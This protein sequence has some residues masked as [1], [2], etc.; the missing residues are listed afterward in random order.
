MRRS[1]VSRARAS[2][3]FC[4]YHGISNNLQ[5]SLKK[6]KDQRIPRG[7]LCEPARR[8]NILENVGRVYRR[9]RVIKSI[10]VNEITSWSF[11]WESP[12][13]AHA[14]RTCIHCRYCAST[15]ES[16]RARNASSRPRNSARHCNQTY[17]YKPT[18]RVFKVNAECRNRDSRRSSF[19]ARAFSII[20]S[21][22][23]RLFTVTIDWISK[24][25][26]SMNSRK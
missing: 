26:E 6:I 11:N 16:K 14:V 2:R 9:Q 3:N 1:E 20:C 13:A 15:G 22:R 24:R 19:S 10:T 4:K 7:R 21:F 18:S 23:S 12:L 25:N 17:N 8:R 5:E